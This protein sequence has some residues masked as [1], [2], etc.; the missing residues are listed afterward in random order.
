VD[1]ARLDDKDVPSHSLEYLAIDRP[2]STTF[3]DELDPIIRVSMWPRPCAGF[4]LE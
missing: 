3:T 2:H 1:L 4:A